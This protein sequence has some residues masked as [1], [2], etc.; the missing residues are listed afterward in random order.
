MLD[1]VESYFQDIEELNSEIHAKISGEI[2]LKK[3]KS[4]ITTDTFGIDLGELQFLLGS[5]YDVSIINC[6]MHVDEDFSF[7][8][9][10]PHDE[11]IPRI[12]GLSEMLLKV[13]AKK[14]R[15]KGFAL[16]PNPR[17]P[18]ITLWIDTD[19]KTKYYMYLFKITVYFRYFG[20]Y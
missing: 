13:N 11:F 19:K 15:M 1:K 5:E 20:T 12:K 9:L 10:V 18:H 14:P 17:G 4:N 8:S 7:M 6:R 2:E 3:K 16:D